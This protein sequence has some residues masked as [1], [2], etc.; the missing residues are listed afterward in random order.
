MKKTGAT[1]V[2]ASTTPIPDD[3]A[4][5]QSNQSII[6]RNQAAAKLM[7]KHGVLTDD[8]YSAINP[9]LPELQNPND[10]HFTAAGYDFLGKT[11]A[12]SI[13]NILKSGGR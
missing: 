2:W 9:R 6:E 4:K 8:L 13:A 3:A 12:Q 11:V 7:E 5:N 10:V 1:L